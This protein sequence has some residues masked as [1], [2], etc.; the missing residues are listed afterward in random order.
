LV[1]LLVTERITATIGA[2]VSAW[3]VN[4]D[5]DDRRRVKVGVRLKLL[6]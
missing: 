5:V 2:V 3:R 4:E 6:V 1:P